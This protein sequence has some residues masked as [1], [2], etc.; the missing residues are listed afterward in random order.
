MAYKRVDS[1]SGFYEWNVERLQA[2]WRMIRARRKYHKQRRAVIVVQRRYRQYKAHVRWR[3]NPNYPARYIQA[4]WRRYTRVKLYHHLR[5]LINF[6][7]TTADASALLRFINPGESR[8]MDA[9]AGTR[10]RL[11]LAG[12]TFPP[13][14]VYKIYTRRPVIDIVSIPVFHYSRAKRQEVKSMQLKRKKRRWLQQLYQMGEQEGEDCPSSSA[15]KEVTEDL[16]EWSKALDF[17]SYLQSWQELGASG[18]SDQ[19]P[20]LDEETFKEMTEVPLLPSFSIPHN[21]LESYAQIIM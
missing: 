7:N 6:R 5:D 13:V 15:G 8:L 11:R 18:Y 21:L 20:S 12:E 17:E 14:I 16:I 9:A 10:V 2:W 19:L 1:A 3:R 4:A